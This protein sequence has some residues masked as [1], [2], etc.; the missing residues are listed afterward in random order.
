MPS[1]LTGI[2]PFGAPLLAAVMLCGW[3]S[4]GAGEPSPRS[5]PAT[6]TLGIHPRRCQATADPRQVLLARAVLRRA[7]PPRGLASGKAAGLDDRLG[8]LSRGV[9]RG[10]R[11][12]RARRRSPD[13]GVRDPRLQR[14]RGTRYAGRVRIP[15]RREEV[16]L[17]PG[18]AQLDDRPVQP[19]WEADGSALLLEIA[20]PGEYRLELTLRPI[21]AARQPSCRPRSGDSPR[22]DLAAGVQRAGGRPAGRVP[23]RPGRRPLGRSQSRWTAELGPADRLAVALAGCR[24]GGRG[25]IVD[26]EQLLWLKIEPGCVL[27]DVRMKAKAAG[28]Q[29]AACSCGPIPP[30]NCFP[31]AV[32]P[33]PSVQ[34]RAA[35][36][37]SDLRDPLAGHHVPMV[38]SGPTAT[39]DLHF[40][41]SGV[42]SLGTSACRKSK[43]STPGPCGDRWPFPSIPPWNIKCPGRRLQE[44][45]RPAG[46]HQP[47]GHG[48]S[49]PEWPSASMTTR[50]NGA[51]SRGPGSP[52]L[53][54]NS[55]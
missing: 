52:R 26:V 7:L 20:E 18:Q 28:G 49:P 8:R 9:G 6:P 36:I 40:L 51:W 47:L 48:D 41:W 34:T 25:T 1:T 16:S 23:F 54:A 27:L 46:V 33:R 21:G 45:A 10:C 2:V 38:G 14:R 31:P 43:S 19:E 11:A 13:R 32:L 39:F 22:A 29:F 37:R 5:P 44:T 3:N 17:E 30:W 4:A 50:R 15:L 55:I 42:S 24:P 12:G 35:A 53:P